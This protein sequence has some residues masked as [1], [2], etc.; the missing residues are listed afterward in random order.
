MSCFHL[1]EYSTPGAPNLAAAP[2][3]PPA[4]ISKAP[5]AVPNSSVL[6]IS[7]PIESTDVALTVPDHGGPNTREADAI[8]IDNSLKLTE[9]GSW[10]ISFTSE[11]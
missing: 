1:K 6:A 7:L 2:S 8:M 5:T 10:R 9:C 11:V 4:T 3:T